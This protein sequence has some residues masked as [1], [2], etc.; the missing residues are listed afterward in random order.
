MQQVKDVYI[1][2]A[3]TWNNFLKKGAFEFEAHLK[4]FQINFTVYY[5]QRKRDT[6]KVYSNLKLLLIS[7]EFLKMLCSF[8]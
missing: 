1:V 5:L 2:T 4:N 3:N 7:F 6:Q 8:D